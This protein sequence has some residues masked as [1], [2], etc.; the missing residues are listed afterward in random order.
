[1]T[2]ETVQNARLKTYFLNDFNQQGCKCAGPGIRLQCRRDCD[3]LALKFGFRSVKTELPN[4]SRIIRTLLS[5]QP[6]PDKSKKQQGP[7]GEAITFSTG[8]LSPSDAQS[9]PDPSGSKQQGDRKSLGQATGDE[10]GRHR[11]PARPTCSETL[12]PVTRKHASPH[13]KQLPRLLRRPTAGLRGSVRPAPGFP[14][15]VRRNS[16]PPPP[17]SD[18][19]ERH[20][21]ALAALTL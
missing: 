21:A 19:G 12:L 16:S 1:M 10:K 2:Q 18:R 11:F 13:S 6:P 8:Q 5:R 4:F 17:A 9:P 3:V 20:P 7:E 15:Q 14:C